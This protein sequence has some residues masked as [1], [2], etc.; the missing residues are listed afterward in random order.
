MAGFFEPSIQ[1]TVDFIRENF[2]GILSMNT[3]SSGSGLLWRTRLKVPVQFAF[4][5]GGFASSPWMTDQLNRRLSDL[6]LAFFK[7]D[8]NT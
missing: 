8:T 2:A 6:G 3:V 7:P 5:V 1:F 4:L